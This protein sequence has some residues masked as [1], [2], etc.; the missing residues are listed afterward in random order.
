MAITPDT[1]LTLI[2]LPI[3]L[4]SN[5]QLTF[6]TA[7]QQH[8]YFDSLTDN[9]DVERFTYQRKDGIIRY[10]AHI[11]TIITYNYCM[12]QNENYGSKWFYAFITDMKYIN[13]NMTEIYISTDVW[14]TWQ[15]DIT[16]N[17]MFVEREIVAST[18]DTFGKYRIDEGLETGD[19]LHI[20]TGVATGLNPYYVIAYTG[21]SLTD[22][23]TIIDIPKGGMS[24][25]GIPSSVPFIICDSL[26]NF[27]TIL[28]MINEA[29][30][31]NNI[32]TCFTVPQVAFDD[33]YV[34]GKMNSTT[35]I[36]WNCCIVSRGSYTNTK[37][38]YRVPHHASF[39]YGPGIF[40]TPK[41]KK[42]LQYPYMYFGTGSGISDQ[43]IYK[44][45]DFY[46]TDGS[47]LSCDEDYNYDIIFDIISEFNPSPT[48]LLLPRG[49]KNFNA[50]S[51]NINDT[52]SPINV[53]KYPTLAYYNDVF[54]SWLAQ[55][56]EILNLNMQQQD[57]KYW[58][59]VLGNSAN[60]LGGLASLGSG[61]VAGG[62]G[63]IGSSLTSAISAGI[64]LEFY[65]RQQ[66]AIKNQQSLLPD[67]VNFGST[68]TLLGYGILTKNLLNHYQLNYEYAKR[69]DDYFSA[70]GYK[71]NEIKVPNINSRNN[72][73]YIKTVGANIF[74]DIPQNDLN[75]IKNMFDTGITFWHNPSTFLDY[76]QTNS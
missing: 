76:S 27:Q 21:E 38:A 61:D 66:L 34:N 60:A 59:N 45:E 65:A 33:C 47:V 46:N 67:N 8:T 69:I 44:Y 28:Q 53:G 17:N 63:Q 1:N 48:C 39:Y 22:G 13:D 49:L 32:I 2:K 16:L 51:V 36:P 64:D 56:S 29:G 35:S 4:D 62:L 40:Y 5:N 37:T 73:N 50:S 10:P 72:W 3:E 18:D 14:Q 11:D 41:N 74:G 75:Q 7:L 12:Y 43:R 68:A 31:G 20:S 52:L 19:H 6:S 30:M 25:N 57:I 54:N 42:L 58:T 55:N 71:I 23:N 15:F 70:Y 24:I 26:S 9:L